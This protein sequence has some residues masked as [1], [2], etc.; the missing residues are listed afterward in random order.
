MKKY[1]EERLQEVAPS[2][3]D[4]W[5]SALQVGQAG[6]APPTRRLLADTSW[7][8]NASLALQVFKSGLLRGVEQTYHALEAAA[9]QANTQQAVKGRCAMGAEQHLWKH[10]LC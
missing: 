9:Y 5:C 3:L 6:L 7:H 8:R 1:I 2:I 10:V 4:S